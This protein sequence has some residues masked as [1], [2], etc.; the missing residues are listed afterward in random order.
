MS[1]QGGA[2]L[3][4]GKFIFDTDP[5]VDDSM[6]FLLATAS[7]E[8][9]MV[10]VTTVFGNGGLE[11][12]T[13]NALRLVELADRPDIPVHAG[14][15]RPLLH[16]YRGEGSFV[17]G[18]DGLG[19]SQ[20]PEPE[21]APRAE[22]AVQYI[23]DTVMGNPGEITLIAVGPLT[24]LALAV[25]LE[26]RLTQAVRQVVIMGGTASRPGNV[27]PVAEANIH[28]DSA[29]ARIVF[30]AGWPLTMVGLDVTCATIM[31]P[32]YL[33]DLWAIGNKATD[34]I[35]RIVPFYQR[36]HKAQG[37]EGIYVHDSSAI[38]YAI[39]PSLFTVRSLPAHVCVDEGM[40]DGQIIPD[41]KEKDTVRPPVN[42]CLQV[43][44]ARFLDM[45]RTRL[46][47]F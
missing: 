17:H 34:F 1:D 12:T 11:T 19:N 5:G 23:V 13:R 8:L 3:R 36:F 33:R 28:N 45:Y 32:D 46:S 40:V 42:V 7:P 26:P 21:G 6:A 24:N 15:S 20:M 38:A 10:G 2:G 14:A 31:S 44:S 43:D 37:V 25:S 39:D 29:A 18:D 41:W 30:E 16:P 4:P 22:H 47:A 9:E 27:T 35:A